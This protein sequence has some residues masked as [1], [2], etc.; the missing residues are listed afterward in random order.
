MKTPPKPDSPSLIECI[1]QIAIKS[2]GSEFSVKFLK[3]IRPYSDQLADFLGCKSREAV[4]WAIIFSINFRT[5]AV[6][7]EDL[8]NYIECHPLTILK[9]NDFENL[10]TLR[11][12]RKDSG[13]TH[14]R[15]SM[16]RDRINALRFYVPREYIDAISDGKKLEP[17]S[18]P[19]NNLSVYEL[20][21]CIGDTI[22]DKD[23][24]IVSFKDM[25]SEIYQLLNDNS[26]LPLVRA[27]KQLKLDPDDLVLLLFTLH[28]FVNY[29]GCSIDL[30]R[31]LRSIF[32][33]DVQYTIRRAFMHGRS[34]LQKKN[35]LQLESADFKSDK[36]IELTEKAVE[37]FIPEEDRELFQ[38]RESKKMD[39]IYAK[40]I[41][42]KRLY[43]N[44][45]ESK[46]LDFLV[47]VL[48]PENYK[49]IIARM[50]EQGLNGGFTVL[51]HGYAGTGKT[52]SVYQIARQT[53]RN[54]KMVVIS[55]TKSHWFGQ[56]EKLI[57]SI[58]DEYRK[59]VEYCEVA[60]ILLF[61]E[62][63]GIFSSR[64]TIGKSSVD[65]TENAIQNII[66]QEM[67]VFNGILIATTNLPKS[68]DSGF[69]RRFSF[70]AFYDK[71][72]E[73]SKYHIWLDK[74]PTLVDGKPES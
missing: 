6:D 3:D 41:K 50:K 72:T 54:I 34:E 29:E 2:R 53:G 12:I 7:L 59:M 65:Q 51:F 20:L 35:L 27:F 42:E 49:A 33:S 58:F 61:N 70:K 26:D 16:V 21:D 11:L 39:V 18:K 62:C 15:R 9:F 36:T 43:F 30:I 64:K 74:I 31:T 55:E 4:W 44:P 45:E 14:R 38:K 52:E 68:L 69:S 73:E 28:Q 23:N 8:S 25:I 24:D 46:S 5:H 13:E 37:I 56:S 22:E 10:L 67:E 40:D 71:P 48:K 1:E 32:P 63:D 57:K 47:D 66:L 17:N 60:P 19:T